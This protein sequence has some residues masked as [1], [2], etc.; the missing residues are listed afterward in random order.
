MTKARKKKGRAVRGVQLNLFGP[1]PAVYDSVT[2]VEAGASVEK[3]ASK[4][5]DAVEAAVRKAGPAGLTDEE[6]VGLLAMS[7]STY[8]PRR[9]ELVDAGLVVNSGTVRKTASG[10]NAVVWIATARKLT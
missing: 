8:R 10:R 5:R 6:G 9:V 2:S 4:L 1:P 3:V 7:P